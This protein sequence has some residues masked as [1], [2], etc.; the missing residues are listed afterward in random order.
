[1]RVRMCVCMYVYVC[2]CAYVHV[3]AR[4]CTYVCTHARACLCTND[5]EFHLVLKHTSTTSVKSIPLEVLIYKRCGI[6]TSWY[7]DLVDS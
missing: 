6:L 1:M 5:V 7:I 3:R 2:V 4:T